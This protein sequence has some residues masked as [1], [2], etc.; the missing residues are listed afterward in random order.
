MVTFSE[1]SHSALHKVMGIRCFFYVDWTIYL[2]DD[3]RVDLTIARGT[4]D[5]SSK[6]I[7]TTATQN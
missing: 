6:S 3:A 2:S 4:F 7:Q 1:I 5:H